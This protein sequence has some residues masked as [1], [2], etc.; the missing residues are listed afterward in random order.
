ME[1]QISKKSKEQNHCK[2][3]R[4]DVLVFFLF[5]VLFQVRKGFHMTASC[6]CY[7]YRCVKAKG[8]GAV[9]RLSGTLSFFPCQ[10]ADKNVL[11]KF[12]HPLE[13]PEMIRERS[14]IGKGKGIRCIVVFG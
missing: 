9:I 13:I 14:L 1:N 5:G 11:G 8:Y 12:F 3:K 10:P 2:S 7:V 4:A 6:F